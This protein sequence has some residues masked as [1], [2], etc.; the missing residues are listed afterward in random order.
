MPHPSNDDVEQGLHDRLRMLDLPEKVRLLSGADFW[1]L[2]A[3]GR[4]GLRRLV[5]SDG[6]AGI[7]GEATDERAPSLNLPCGSALGAMWDP[8][9]AR[10]YGDL[11]GREARRKGADVVLGPTINL[12]RSPY[13]GRHFEA[14]SEDPQL[15]ARMAAAYV[16]GIQAHGV[17]ACPKHYVAN[18]YEVERHTASSEIDDRALRE[19]YL[20]AFEDAIVEARSWVVMSAYNGVNGTTMSEHDLL[21]DPLKTEWGFDGVVLSDWVAVKTTEASA[22]AAQDVVMPGFLS[23]WG[24]ALVSAVREGRVPE[25]AVDEKLLRLLRLAARVGALDGVKPAPR[26][27]A[28]VADPQRTVTDL[29]VE[30]MVLLH[31]A[32]ELP[33]TQQP[34]SIAVIGPHAMFARTQGGGSAAVVPEHVVAPLEGLRERFPE[35]E[36]SFHMGVAAPVVIYPFDRK[37]IHDPGTGAPGAR[38]VVTDA[39]GRVLLDEIRHSTELT[40][41]GTLPESA[42]TMVLHTRWTPAAAERVDLGVAAACSIRVE[43][44]GQVAIERDADGAGGDVDLGAASPSDTTAATGPPGDVMAAVFAPP[45]T[46]IPVETEVGVP[47][48]VVVTCDLTTAPLPMVHALTVGM[49][50]RSGTAEEMRD[51]AVAAAAAAEVAV[52]VVGTSARTESEGFD[53]ST[54]VMPGGQDDLVHA[55]LAANP[56][57]VVVVNA[58]S[59]VLM[60]WRDQAGAVLL[61]WFGGQQTGVA[62]AEVLAGDREPGGRLPTT[63]PADESSVPIGPDVPVGGLVHYNEG[64]DIGY[65]AWLRRDRTPAYWFGHGLGYTTWQLTDLD[66]DGPVAGGADVTVRVKVTNTGTRTGKQ[67]VQVYASRA[68]SA[69]LRPVR[70]LVGW[71]VARLAAGASTVLEIDVPARSLAAWR[72]GAWWHESGRFTLH[73]GT[74]VG[75]ECVQ[76][77]VEVR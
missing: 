11:L 5:F 71:G 51:V 2:P 3:E 34:R 45:V 65:R 24:D 39:Q 50:P 69:V 23:P 66:V 73:V 10:K 59:P 32:A 37:R 72:D 41:L 6:P 4:I 75:A 63:W 61:S 20:A 70:W 46:S 55:V 57:T 52:V 30:S 8:G 53:R 28:E 16:E 67:V 25:S 15:T 40:W 47:V 77:A 36:I 62:L 49:A 18:D 64:I 68:E 35:A 31:N 54:L 13:G 19:L 22:N 12:H 76:G 58:G 21:R 1:S 74:S 29:G 17:A 43:L 56:R 48:D 14:M 42:A 26:T 44:D 60:P 33:W 9:A 27:A 7:R 38:L